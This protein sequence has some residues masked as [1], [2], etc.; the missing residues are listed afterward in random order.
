MSRNS[1]RLCEETSCDALPVHQGEQWL[2]QLPSDWPFS[3]TQCAWNQSTSLRRSCRNFTSSCDCTVSINRWSWTL[4]IY[5]EVI[6]HARQ[7]HCSKHEAW[8]VSKREESAVHLRNSRN[9]QIELNVSV[10]I[11]KLYNFHLMQHWRNVSWLMLTG[12]EKLFH[13]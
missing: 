12:F 7:A 3:F 6:K 4:I 10:S 1:P 8:S 13:N 5:N 11:L 2:W 9:H